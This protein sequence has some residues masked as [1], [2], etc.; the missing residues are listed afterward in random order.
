ML[1]PYSTPFINTYD[2][3]T[4]TDEIIII[5]ILHVFIIYQLNRQPETG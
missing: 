5:I 2:I 4:S 1:I 3:L